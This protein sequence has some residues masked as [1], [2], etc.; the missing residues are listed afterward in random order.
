MMEKDGFVEWAEVRITF[1]TG[2]ELADQE[3]E[4][5]GKGVKSKTNPQDL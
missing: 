4:R 2:E 3:R 5:Q 1:R